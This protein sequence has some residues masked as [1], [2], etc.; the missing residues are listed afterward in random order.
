MIF[1][2]FDA[3]LEGLGQKFKNVN[4][5]FK[6]LL[7]GRPYNGRYCTT[8]LYLQRLNILYIGHCLPWYRGRCTIRAV[9][10]FQ[11]AVVSRGPL[12]IGAVVNLFGAVVNIR[13]LYNLGRRNV[14]AV[15]RPTRF[16]AHPPSEIISIMNFIF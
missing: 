8:A 16:N 4:S 2:K 9:V 5:L 15:V 10:M 11:E 1:S 3:I 12:Y 13:P 14:L 6:V 7:T